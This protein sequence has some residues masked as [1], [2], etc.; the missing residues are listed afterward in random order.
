MREFLFSALDVAAIISS[1]ELGC[2]DENE[3]IDSIWNGEKAF[4][5]SEYRN[6]KRKFILDVYYWLQY[7]YEKPILDQEFPAL[8]QDMMTSDNT[9]EPEQ[10]MSDFSNL[11]LF[12]KKIRIQILYGKGNDY[13]RV[14]LRTLLKHYG[15]KRRSQ[16]LIQHINR[17]L[18]F[19][20]FEITVRGGIPCLIEDATLDQMLIF[21]VI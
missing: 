20:H 7:F 17:C 12:F 10:Y 18:Y 11:D 5:V 6:N 4:L 16:L 15:Y 19:Y 1:M 21:H 13:V 2:R 14:K 9:I 8:C 3:M